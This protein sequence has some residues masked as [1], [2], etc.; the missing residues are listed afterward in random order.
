MILR[1]KFCVNIIIDV[2]ITEVGLLKSAYHFMGCTEAFILHTW[3][4][5]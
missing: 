2:T 3:S 4:L 5:T 1:H